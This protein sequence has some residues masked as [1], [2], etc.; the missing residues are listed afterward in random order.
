MED[1]KRI[2]RWQWA[3]GVPLALVLG[4]LLQAVLFEV[5]SLNVQIA[6]LNG[7]LGLLGLEVPYVG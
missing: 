7:V 1:K 2:C 4:V 3:L 5:K 6:C